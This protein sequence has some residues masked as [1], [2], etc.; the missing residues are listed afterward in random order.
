M[1]CCHVTYIPIGINLL[2]EIS[3]PLIHLVV[4]C[5][6][7]EGNDV[8]PH[9]RAGMPPK[10]GLCAANSP[11]LP[12]GDEK[13]LSLQFHI[14]RQFNNAIHP[15]TLPTKISQFILVPNYGH[16]EADSDR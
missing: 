2:E 5:N 8:V 16:R 13:K 3:I 10:G 15:Y 7:G 6:R 11:N 4:H 14:P 9:E 12:Y 1:D